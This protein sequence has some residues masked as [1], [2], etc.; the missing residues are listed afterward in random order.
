MTSTTRLRMG[1]KVFLSYVSGFVP[2]EGMPLEVK[3]AIAV[4]Y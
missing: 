3:S 4:P 1:L 2:G